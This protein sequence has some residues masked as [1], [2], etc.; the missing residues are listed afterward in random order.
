[1]SKTT[2]RTSA[3]GKSRIE[4]ILSRKMFSSGADIFR[5]GIAYGLLKYP[6]ADS[7]PEAPE[8][9]DSLTYNFGSIDPS[10]L[11]AAAIRSNYEFE[12]DTDVLDLMVKLGEAGI[13]LLH[14]A[15]MDDEVQTPF[16]L[17]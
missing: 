7:V 15:I 6:S 10:N 3:D 1:M 14:E 17:E 11:L 5:A 4:D 13:S 2:F 16:E 9:G 12:P 8:A